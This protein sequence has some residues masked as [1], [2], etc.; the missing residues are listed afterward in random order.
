M[1]EDTLIL[2]N[3]YY[4]KS[5]IFIYILATLGNSVTFI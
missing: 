5:L 2:S 1:T 3:L 4:S